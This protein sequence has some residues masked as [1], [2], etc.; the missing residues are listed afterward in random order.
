[1][2]AKAAQDHRDFH[3]RWVTLK[4]PL[5]PHENVAAAIRE[6]L[7]DHDAAAPVLL[8]GVTPELAA[9]PRHTI[10]VDWSERMVATAWPGDS[11]SRRAVLGDWRRLPLADFS[12]AAAIGDGCLSMLH[13]PD[14]QPVLMAFL[15]L[16]VRP[17]GRAVF[18][19]F[20]TP[21]PG[22]TVDEVR[23]AVMAGGLGFH[24]FKLRFNM[25]VALETGHENVSSSRLFDR[26]QAIFPD[27]Q[28][29]AAASGWSLAAI[30]EIDAY[31]SS[32]YIHCYPSRR[33]VI[34]L[35]PD[36]AQARF[37]ETHGYPLAERCPL[38]VVNFP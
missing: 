31:E 24:A 36:W 33:Q 20:A 5:R 30:A 38:L 35:M 19:C 11:E 1:M 8:L 13:Y 28:A 9:I 26:F 37:V 23:E 34:E 14:E 27:R 17:G 32:E 12:V 6:L 15:R 21:D 3:R 22:E 4:P 16:A 18:R 25:A 7:P 2:T 29:L 10:A